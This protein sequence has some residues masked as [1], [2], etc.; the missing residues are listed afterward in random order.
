[1]QRQRHVML[2]TKQ[3]SDPPAETVGESCRK[4]ICQCMIDG[5]DI[6]PLTKFIVGCACVAVVVVA[7]GKVN[8]T[9]Q[10]GEAPLCTKLGSSV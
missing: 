2:I 8:S 7:V 6:F 10:P 9:A 1:M 3:G 4:L 5:G